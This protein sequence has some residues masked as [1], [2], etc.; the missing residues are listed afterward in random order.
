MLLVKQRLRLKSCVINLV[1]KMDADAYCINLC[2]FVVKTL[3]ITSSYANY[4]DT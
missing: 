3:K 1:S 2:A 4:I